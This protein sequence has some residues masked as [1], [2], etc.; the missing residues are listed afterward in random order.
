[1]EWQIGDFAMGDAP[2]RLA[3]TIE[4]LSFYEDRTER[5][6]AL[7]DLAARFEDVPASVASRP[8][9]ESRHVAGCESQ[10]F[11]FEARRD[12][13]TLDFFFAVENPQGVSAK[14]LAVILSDSLS[15]APL[16]EVAALDPDLIFDIFGN[17]LSMGK[18]IGLGGIVSMVRAAAYREQSEH[19]ARD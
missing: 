14:A 7:V 8:F 12:D 6:Q 11:V 13:G 4:A 18:T 16:A 2:A 19:E 17:E 3:A 5:I 10:A 1:M 15:G 9:D